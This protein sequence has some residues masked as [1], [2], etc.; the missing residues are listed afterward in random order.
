[1]VNLRLAG[2]LNQ[3]LTATTNRKTLLCHQPKVSLKE[4][5]SWT[6][7]WLLTQRLA[8]KFPVAGGN[9]GVV[10]SGR[11]ELEER[12]TWSR[13]VPTAGMQRP[14]SL[15]VVWLEHPIP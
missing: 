13:T 11:T 3:P 9:L 10:G 2:F 14:P 1:M 12:Q 5:F 4:Q 6:S 15:D 7:D 8:A